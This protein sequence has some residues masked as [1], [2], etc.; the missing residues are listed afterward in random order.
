MKRRLLIA[1]AVLLLA[2]GALAAAVELRGPPEWTRP[3]APFHMVGNV[4]DVGSAGITSLLI[5]TADGLILIDPGMP[6]FAPQV[7]ANI[8]TLGYD[9]RRV[10]WVLNSHAHFDHAGGLAQF[11]RDTGASLAAMGPDVRQLE[12]GTYVGA[13]SNPVLRFD[14]VHVDRVLKD[15]D[16][17]GLG[18]VVLTAHVTPGHSPGDTTWTWTTSEGGRPLRVM[19]QGS[20]SVA[21]NRLAGPPQYPGIVADYRRTFAELKA[22]HADVFLAPHAEQFGLAEKKAH[23]STLAYV[24]PGELPRRVAEGE[25]AFDKALAEQ[26]AKAAA[27]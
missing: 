11:K 19:Y 14:P 10:R 17:V 2:G 25:A 27:R 20:F 15:G 16:T 3:V 22:M 7:E 13:E 8:R 26:T 6:G 23:G 4:Y 24:D 1:G 5:P 12:T 9:P 21:A 18:G